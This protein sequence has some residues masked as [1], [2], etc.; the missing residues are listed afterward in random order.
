MPQNPPIPLWL[1][2][3][4]SKIVCLPPITTRLQELP[5]EKLTWENFER[6]CLRLVREE[7]EVEDCRQY[8]ERGDNQ[9]GIDIYARQQNREKYSVYQCKREQ[10]FGPSK[11]K[12][13]VTEFLN[14]TWVEKTDLFVLCTQESLKVRQR[15][16]E[17]IKQT[18]KLKKRG[19]SFIAWD[20]NELNIKL[21]DYPEI[22]DD[23][24]G[25][26]F[27]TAFCGDGQAANP[28]NK[29]E[30]A[31]P[32]HD[33]RMWLVDKTAHFVVPGL[34]QSFS[35]T[36]D[37]VPIN[38]RCI[39]G[40]K[41]SFKAELIAEL[42]KYCVVVGD[43]GSGKSTLIRRLANH[44]TNVGKQVLLVRLPEVLRLHKKG[45]TFSE[46]I[47]DASTD[48]LNIDRT[49]SRSALNSPDYL[50]ADGLDECTTDRV[51]ITEK[52]NS[53]AK[54]HLATKI[55]VA[56]R[57][58]YELELLSEWEQVEIQT[59]DKESIKKF[60]S[61]LLNASA[62]EK[63][64]LKKAL[65]SVEKIL[66]NDRTFSLIATNPLL[67]GFTTRL[68]GLGIDVSQKSRTELYKTL[69][70]LAYQDLPQFRE[71]I[72]F[73]KQS[74]KRILEI[75]GWNLMHQPLLTEDELT[76]ALGNE[77]QKNGYT[78]QQAE[79]EA[80][81]GIRFWEDKRI[82]NRSKFEYQN[83]ITFVHLS[84][85]EYAAGQYA[86]K[87]KEYDLQMWIQEVRSDIKWRDTICFAGGL[88]SGE[89]IV[90]YLL[91]LDNSRDLI[92]EEIFLIVAVIVESEE[93]S[94]KVLKVVIDRIHPQLK[95][96]SC[97]IAFEATTL[98]L[99]ISLKASS[100][101]YSVVEPLLRNSQFWTRMAAM[102][103]ALVCDEESVDLNILNQL[104][105]DIIAD[106]VTP[107]S[108]PFA[109]KRKGCKGQWHIRNQVILHGCQLILK[110]QPNLDSYNRILNL[111]SQAS[112]SVGT[113]NSVEELLTKNSMEMLE[114]AEFQEDKQKWHA[115]WWNISGLGKTFKEFNSPRGRL[116]QLQRLERMEEARCADRAFLEAIR[117]VTMTLIE[118]EELSHS[119]IEPVALGTLLKGMG[120]WEMPG[121]EWN[122]L[123]KRTDLD[124][125]DTVVK[126]MII[127]LNIDMERLT[128][129]AVKVMRDIDRFFSFDLDSVKVVLRE[130]N[131]VEGYLQQLKYLFEEVYQD[132]NASG[133]ILHQISRVPITYKWELV[134]NL[135][136][137]AQ[138]LAGA[139][140][141]PSQLICQNA[142]LLIK[143]GAGGEAA[144][145]LAKE[146]M[147]EDEWKT[148]AEGKAVT[149]FCDT[150]ASEI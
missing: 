60:I 132:Q 108:L 25:S 34:S 72:E 101:I 31:Y 91:N 111:I 5:F 149:A 145:K 13:A 87:L 117:R 119:F 82:F 37:W 140:E 66:E 100:L 114:T 126:G 28:S 20:S 55:I 73:N 45:K 99:S 122:I 75:V 52:L 137:S 76:E 24:F 51:D 106:P 81:R 95:S 44:L 142:V 127:A 23:F 62:I 47:L 134:A 79:I 93:I 22:I 109:R 118:H 9:D 138:V 148:F 146:V 141:H 67:L 128:I 26:A 42:Y 94:S 36:T 11:I 49:L 17:C 32:I 89:K 35:I 115:F 10:N 104:I 107:A 6:L 40:D 102:S 85:C 92:S 98:L 69:I 124:A 88:G 70:D 123:C 113:V 57:K 97:E 18:E 116:E 121:N 105:E 80:E 110:K 1:E 135:E 136:L 15:A 139:L 2:E 8:G 90:E 131:I 16:D 3:S 19:I 48:G 50:L 71:T 147:G 30:Q 43:S 78:L 133:G 129:E 120:W 58:S 68:I 4:P 46:A 29:T 64:R 41:E 63:S 56:N 77:L 53:W 54:G 14:G 59:L 143:Y 96:F 61:K 150:F 27:V 86:S 33:Y 12:A 38:V 39:Q 83:T 125:V 74:A 84:L 144:V 130:N 112:L 7:A 103:L 65:D 21:K